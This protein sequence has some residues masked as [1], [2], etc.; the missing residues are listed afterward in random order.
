[1]ATQLNPDAKEFVPVS[2]TRTG[3]NM[4]NLFTNLMD[5]VVS[6]SPMKGDNPY[7]EETL[8]LPS[9]SIFDNEAG[10]RPHDLDD[11][12]TDFM[13]LKE[14][15]QRDDKLEQEYKDETQNNFQE[16]VMNK[17]KEEYAELEKSFNDYSNGFQNTI[18]DPMNRSFY[19]GRDNDLLE[20]ATQKDILNSCQPIPTFEDEHPEADLMQN[21]NNFMVSQDEILP[22]QMVESLDNFEPEKFVEEIKKANGDVDKYTDQGLSPTIEI[23][24]AVEEPVIVSTPAVVEQQPQEIIQEPA[25]IVPDPVVVDKV[26]KVSETPSSAKKP[27]ATPTSAAK[28]TPI[29]K[30]SASSTSVK[31]SPAAITKSPAPTKPPATA[32]PKVDLKAKAPVPKVALTKKPATSTTSTTSKPATSTLTTS[33]PKTTVSATSATTAIKKTTSTVSASA[34]APRST[35]LVKKT[36]TT[37]VSSAPK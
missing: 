36:S 32:A 19:E 17:T 33:R 7:L 21:G 1:M 11:N 23:S 25:V 12:V 30:S 18:D 37:T 15:M 31:K 35:T 20:Q 9:E 5:S 4:A 16:D 10:V 28:K 13:N 6:Q 27:A 22:Q 2:P 34:A 14:A 3:P 8:N 24:P 29:T 26:A